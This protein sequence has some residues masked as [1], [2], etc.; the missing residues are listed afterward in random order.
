MSQTPFRFVHASDFH[1]ERPPHGISEAPDHLRKIF[2]DAPYRAAAKVF[3]LALAEQVDFLVLCGDLLLP[4]ATGPRGPLFLVEQFTRLQERGVQVYW[5]GGQVDPPENWPAF[6]RLPENV[7]FFPEKRP[8]EIVHHRDG[9]P[10]ARLVGLSRRHNRKLKPGD[11]QPD[12]EGL[13][14]IAAT[15]GSIDKAA[16]ANRAI[17]YWALGGRHQRETIS[18]EPGLA[19]YPGTIQGREPSETGP[20]GC[21]VVDV[22]ADGKVRTRLAPT[23]VVRWRHEEIELAEPT[24]RETL[25]RILLDRLRTVAATTP[26]ADQLVSWTVGGAFPLIAPFRSGAFQSEM[27]TRLR[28]ELGYASPAVWS[29]SLAAEAA[30]ASEAWYG[31]ETILG[32]FL[33]AMRDHRLAPDDEPSSL[34]LTRCLGESHADTELASAVKLDDAATRGR[35]LRRAAILGADLLSGEEAS[36]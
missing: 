23:D 22:D 7:Q 5:A 36:L 14:S 4:E 27:L 16:V 8:E 18:E 19:H 26:G 2:L 28:N 32:D 25:E 12:A 31:Q 3:D 33:R 10:V 35:V 20:H 1:L 34:D 11:F 21:T 30:D 17:H 6:A 29:I 24:T 9:E 13:F 15:H